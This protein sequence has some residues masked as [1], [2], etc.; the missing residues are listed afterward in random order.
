LRLDGNPSISTDNG[1]T[2]KMALISVG[3]MTSGATGATFTFT[4]LDTVLLATQAGSIR[5]SGI[6]FQ[7]IDQLYFYAR[8][9]TSDL[10]LGATLTDIDAAILQAERDVQVNAPAGVDAL[11]VFAGNDFLTGTGPITATDIL[12]VDALRNVNFTSSQFPYGTS[13]THSL[14]LRAGNLMN[15]DVTG[16]S[17]VFANARSVDVSG[18]TINFIGA[19]TNPLLF[20][21]TS[22]VTFTA[23]AGGVLGKRPRWNTM[24]GF[25]IYS[26]AERSGSGR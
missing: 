15:I 11:A 22:P 16:D 13:A 2:T 19:A 25:S 9:A 4:P 10:I 24:G 21:A 5:L 17:S 1:G 7:G 12:I 18:N 8:G 20:A 23:G 14:V 26:P 6:G 3:D